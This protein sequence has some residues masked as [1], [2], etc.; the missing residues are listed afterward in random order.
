MLAFFLAFT[1]V[2]GLSGLFDQQTNDEIS[3]S[4]IQA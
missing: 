3:Q 2:Q 1:K 4:H